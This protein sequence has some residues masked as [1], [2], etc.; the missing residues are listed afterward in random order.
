MTDE[1]APRRRKGW[2]VG[3]D[4][5]RYRD[6]LRSPAWRAVRARFIA[7]RIPKLCAGC[8]R[9]WG[10]GDHLHHKSY[11]RL[12][13]ERLS[14]LVPLC[15]SCHKFVHDEVG[16]D[17]A[18]LWAGTRKALQRRRRALRLKPRGVTMQL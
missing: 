12:G 10:P 15:A 18:M 3:P 8:D 5:V 4:P 13:A 7:S 6:Y 9:A 11:N 16:P 1:A 17:F 2:T 14:D